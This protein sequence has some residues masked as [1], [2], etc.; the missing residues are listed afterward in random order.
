MVSTGQVLGFT[1]ASL[2]PRGAVAVSG[3]RREGSVDP[4]TARN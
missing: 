1:L 3:V 2:V 4:D